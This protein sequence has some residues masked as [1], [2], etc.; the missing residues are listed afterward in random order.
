MSHCKINRKAASPNPLIYRINMIFFFSLLDSS[1]ILHSTLKVFSLL[2]NLGQYDGLLLILTV[3]QK[4]VQ[5]QLLN[6]DQQ[7]QM[8]WLN[9]F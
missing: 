6:Q 7:V 4:G 3:I 9:E 5:K 8:T 2:K 1:P